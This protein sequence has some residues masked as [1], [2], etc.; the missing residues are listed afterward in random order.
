VALGSNETNTDTMIVIHIDNKIRKITMFSVPRDL[1][2]KSRRINVVFDENGPARFLKEL[3]DITGL[4][5]EKYI[6]I[7]MSAF[8]DAVDVI[9]GIDYT[10]ENDLIDPSYK[11]K[12]DGVWSTLAYKKGTYH[13]GGRQALRIAR[14]RHFTSDFDRA[15]RQQ[16]IVVAAGE[17]VKTLGIQNIDKIYELFTLLLKYVSTNFNILEMTSYFSKFKDYRVDF[18]HVIDTSNVLYN[19]YSNL[20]LL[21]EEDRE[22]ARNTE[23][24]EKGAWIVL[25]KGN[26]WNVI[27]WY[28]RE[29][30]TKN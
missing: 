4:K 3:S 28:V 9:G 7:N 1:Y 5:I 24:F 16:G 21:S 23:D 25:P 27:R 22:A 14:S 20:Y 13:L 11:I 15:K 19:T 17:K 30:V 26:D 2:Y 8:I 6:A 18:A 10:L 12:E 29:L